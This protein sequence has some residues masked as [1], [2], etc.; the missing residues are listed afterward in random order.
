MIDLFP[1]VIR[2]E[3]A[4]F[5]NYKCTFCPVGRE[6]GKRGLLSY[7][8]FLS[9]FNMLPLPRVLVLYHGGE[10]LL[11]KDLPRMARYA[12]LWGVQR[13]IVDSNI[14]MLDLDMDLSSIDELRVAFAGK[15]PEEHEQIRKGADYKHDVAVIKQLSASPNRPY[16]I[17][18]LSI[19]DGRIADYLLDEFTGNGCDNGIMFQS[20][21]EKE[22][23]KMGEWIEPSQ[24]VT[25]CRNLMTTFT[26]LANGD[27]SLCSDDLM[28]VS[29]HGNVFEDTPSVIWKRMQPLRD[30]FR[31]GVYPELCQ[32][33]YVV[34][35][36]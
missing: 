29:V 4:G 12:K 19:G 23:P 8:D 33:C 13:I 14:S 17:V 20:L 36:F 11:N 22:W 3:P 5:C 24:P 25:Y 30:G 15:S 26:I 32:S 31:N 2:I 28:G 18:I 9:I 16:R 27:V 7:G 10:P 21:V 1:D 6:G 34:K 35:G